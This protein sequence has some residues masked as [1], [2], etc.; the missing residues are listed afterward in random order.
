MKARHILPSGAAGDVV[1][2]EGRQTWNSLRV[3]YCEFG[4]RMQN[5]AE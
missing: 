2:V 4:K 5:N 3:F 1:E